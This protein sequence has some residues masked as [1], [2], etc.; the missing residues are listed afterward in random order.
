MFVM[1][2]TTAFSVSGQNPAL[3]VLSFPYGFGGIPWGM[4]PAAAAAA[5][6]AGLIQQV[7][8]FVERSL[9]KEYRRQSPPPKKKKNLEMIIY[10][11]FP[12]SPA[13]FPNCSFSFTASLTGMS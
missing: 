3:S 4:Y 11:F 7:L 2:K 1:V 12:L 10:I 6:A 13:L 9:T 8:I 5:A